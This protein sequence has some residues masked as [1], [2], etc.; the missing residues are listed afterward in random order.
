MRS[1][2]VFPEL[3]SEKEK[4]KL[5]ELRL[6]KMKEDRIET[7]LIGVGNHDTTEFDIVVQTY[8]EAERYVKMW[9]SNK[10]IHEVMADWFERTYF[11]TPGTKV[12]SNFPDGYIT[13]SECLVIASGNRKFAIGV[14]GCVKASDEII[15]LSKLEAD[16]LKKKVKRAI[17]NLYG[18]PVFPEAFENLP[19]D[20]F[21]TGYLPVEGRWRSVGFLVNDGSE[22]IGFVAFKLIIEKVILENTTKLPLV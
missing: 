14:G 17:G 13:S 10:E 9:L 12:F 11:S 3:M 18:F 21:G 4:T 6:K 2:E 20:D 1:V 8:G 5:K 15:I 22:F 19:D 7:F 16:E